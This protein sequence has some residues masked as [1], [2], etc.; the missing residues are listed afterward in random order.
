MK[1]ILRKPITYM[2]ALAAIGLCAYQNQTSDP[3]NDPVYQNL[4]P[5]VKPGDN[6]FNYANGGWIK[7][8]PIPAAYSSW[9]IGNVLQEEIRD[10]LKKITDDALKANAP[11][12]TATQK[13]GD[14]YYTGLD[15]AG[16]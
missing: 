12:G 5:T 15:S 4:D 16:I 14:F 10:R 1:V 3:K 9:G 13:I 2:A 6:F 8:N 7:R 11:A